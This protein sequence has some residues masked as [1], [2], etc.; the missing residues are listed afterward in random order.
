[1]FRRKNEC[2]NQ[3]ND[4]GD[5]F[6]SRPLKSLSIH[7]GRLFYF[8]MFYVYII[9]SQLDNTFYK[10]F[11]MQPNLRLLQH[12]NKESTYTSRKTPW[13][14]IHLELFDDKTSALK[15]EKRLKKYSHQQ[16]AELI[17]GGK[18]KL[19]E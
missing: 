19:Q 2:N 10:G 6:T 3:A 18:N 8:C 12:N 15:R 5:G 7:F 4:V 16:I 14:L 13:Q 9:Q 17:R 11:T 1:M